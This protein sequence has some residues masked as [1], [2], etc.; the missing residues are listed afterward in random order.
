MVN[1]RRFAGLMLGASLAHAQDPPKEHH[2]EVGGARI[3]VTLDPSDF[4]LPPDALL[5]WVKESA[6]AVSG[7]YEKFP[8]SHA[9]I[10]V[11]QGRRAGVGGGRTFGEG[12]ARTRIS[13]GQHATV[14]ELKEDW[15]MTHEMVHYGFPSMEERHHWIEEGSATYVEP[16]ARARIGQLTP[17]RVW[18]DMIRDM[19]QGLPQSGD[20]GLDNTHTWGRTYWGG[21]IFCLRADVGIRKHSGNQKGLEH[22]LRAI[23]RAGGMI[24]VDWPL[25]KALKIGD[26]ATGG[27]VLTDL[28]REMGPNPSPV[29]LPD[30]WKQLGVNRNG[31]EVTFDDHAP[32]AAIR[33]AIFQA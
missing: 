17:Q 15:V 1:R 32:L 4:D 9:R 28:Y 2:L 20:E 21:A 33:A 26:Q 31:R 25:E 30:L 5:S 27:T 16:I 8:V 23:N 29:D 24:E 11:V 10:H 22:A 18:G 12:G 7:Y 13:V 19:P 6:R 14:A 3:D